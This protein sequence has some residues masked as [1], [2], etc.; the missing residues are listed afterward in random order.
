[1]SNIAFSWQKINALCW[2]TMQLVFVTSSISVEAPIPQSIKSCLK[3]HSIN[4]TFP[5]IRNRNSSNARKLSYFRAINLAACF[6]SER[7][8][9]SAS[10][11]LIIFWC[12]GCW[13]VKTNLGWLQT[14]CKYRNACK[15]S[16][17][18][19][20]ETIQIFK[21]EIMFVLETTDEFRESV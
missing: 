11:W 5:H 1:M 4:E 2:L 9:F 10:S 7:L 6:I 20:L 13:G 8:E 16:F 17:Q 19:T 21:I 15:R 3:I 14:L 18:E 12:R